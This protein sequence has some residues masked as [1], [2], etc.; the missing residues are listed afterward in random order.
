VIEPPKELY[1]YCST[2]TAFA[3]LDSRT[4]RLSALAFANDSK[5][6]KRVGDDFSRRLSNSSVSKALSDVARVT[7]LGYAGHTDGFA[8]CLSEEKDILGQWRAYADDACGFSIGFC[9][10]ALTQ[11]YGHVP[12]GSSFFELV[13]VKY[14]E[15]GLD[16]LLQPIVSQLEKFHTLYGDVTTLAEG[17]SVLDALELV[18]RP[19]HGQYVYSILD[20]SKKLQ[21]EKLLKLLSAVHFKIYNYKVDSFIEE[22]EWRLL[23]FRHK[24]H[25]PEIDYLATSRV[26]KPFIPCLIADPA[27]EVIKRVVLGPKNQTNIEWVKAFLASRNL[28]H[29]EVERSKISSYR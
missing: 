15:D 6:G 20:R 1:H 10:K 2:Q 19:G 3:I 16:E 21:V 24:E 29:V 12:F 9:P 23:R 22:K 7:I 27:R 25:F 13:K 4:I 11:D 5:E 26:I 8:F 28:A 18:D 17:L 14:G